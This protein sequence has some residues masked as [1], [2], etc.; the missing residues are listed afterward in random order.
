MKTKKIIFRCDGGKD[1]GFGHLKRCL[2]LA[3]EFKFY[4]NAQVFFAIRGDESAIEL[5]R[6][7]GYEILSNL[8]SPKLK[9]HNS[10]IAL[11]QMQSFLM[12][13]I[14]QREVNLMQLKNWG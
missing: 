11:S 14:K 3:H 10:L 5:A 2:S 13:E 6:N 9:L 1:V 12:L 7:E 8:S 4:H